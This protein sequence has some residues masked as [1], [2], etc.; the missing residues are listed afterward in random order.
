MILIF[1]TVFG[2]F[3]NQIEIKLFG[4]NISK[5]GGVNINH[6]FRGQSMPFIHTQINSDQIKNKKGGNHA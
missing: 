1:Q 5:P 6:F 3:L 4:G 2:S